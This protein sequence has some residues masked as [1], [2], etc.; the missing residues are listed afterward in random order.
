MGEAVEF[1]IGAPVSANDG[2]CGKLVRVVVDP[3]ARTVTHIVVEPKHRQ[4]QGRLVPV[5]LVDASSREMRLRCSVSDFEELEFAE[6]THSCRG[7]RG[8]RLRK[9]RGV[10]M[11]LLRA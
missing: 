5:R 11:A 10:R 7:R 6:E 1:D 3:V 8:A 4:G 2:A 9:R